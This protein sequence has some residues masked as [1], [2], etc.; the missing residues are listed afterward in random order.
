M[1]ILDKAADVTK[2]ARQSAYGHPLDNH[3]CT[4]DMW[5]AYVAKRFGVDLQL[6][7]LDV[8][9]MMILLKVSRLAHDPTHEDNWVDI[10]GYARNAEVIYDEI[11]AIKEITE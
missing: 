10:A 1:T 4:A 11:M 2:N 3:G 5:A 7:A 9:Y 8:C 6:T